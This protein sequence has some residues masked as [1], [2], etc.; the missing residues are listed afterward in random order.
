M[1]HTDLGAKEAGE[2]LAKLRE[3]SADARVVG[4]L[5]VLE[6][7]VQAVAAAVAGQARR[8]GRRAPGGP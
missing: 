3:Q 8:R 1:T 6:A 7:K 4:D 2:G 5:A